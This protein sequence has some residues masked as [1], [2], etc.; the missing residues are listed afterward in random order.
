MKLQQGDVVHWVSC[1]AGTRL[2][3]CGTVVAV[4]PPNA[5][6]ERY[7][8]RFR[9]C[10]FDTDRG[11]RDHESYIVYVAERGYYWPRVSLLVPIGGVK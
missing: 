1:S 5:D 6:V 2:P 11:G 7:C 8:R 10:R 4:V 3:K 9:P